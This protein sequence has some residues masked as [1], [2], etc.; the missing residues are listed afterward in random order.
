MRVLG[1]VLQIVRL[2]CIDTA[3]AWR[4]TQHIEEP[5]SKKKKNLTVAG[6]LCRTSY[7]HWPKTYNI[8]VALEIS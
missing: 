4:A 2:A 6:N 7:Y 5:G 3:K 8:K 1:N